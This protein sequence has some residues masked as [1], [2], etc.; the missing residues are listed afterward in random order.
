M[1]KLYWETSRKMDL[2][3]ITVARKIISPYTLP[4]EINVY[5]STLVNL[6]NIIYHQL[7]N[8]K[9]PVYFNNDE[10]KM[11]Y[12]LKTFHVNVVFRETIKDNEMWKHIPL[13]KMK[14]INNN[15]NDILGFINE[16]FK[17]TFKDC[18]ILSHIYYGNNCLLNRCSK[19]KGEK[20][21]EILE[22]KY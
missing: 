11:L 6:I 22:E 14:I 20:I 13:T 12:K 19:E 2:V 1:V 10:Y 5:N 21:L 17:S 9:F 7:I 8:I 18:K 3:G 4:N 15:L 16:V